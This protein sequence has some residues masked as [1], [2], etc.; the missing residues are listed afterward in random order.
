MYG[1]TDY[2]LKVVVKN[3]SSI[4]MI[5]KENRTD[6]IKMLERIVCEEMNY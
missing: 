5:D 6:G 2:E 4:L 3:K 1:F